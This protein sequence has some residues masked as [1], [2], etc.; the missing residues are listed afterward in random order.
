MT[1]GGLRQT[2]AQTEAS[3][4][5]CCISALNL[6]GER[7]VILASFEGK[8]WYSDS[9]G[10]PYNPGK[11]IVQPA[12]AE[13]AERA[14]SE[15]QYTLVGGEGIRYSKGWADTNV[16]SDVALHEG[17]AIT[18]ATS[19]LSDSRTRSNADW[20][21]VCSACGEHFATAAS[22]GQCGTCG[23][24]KCPECRGCDCLNSQAVVCPIC[25]QSLSM[26]EVSKG[27]TVHEDC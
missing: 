5:T 4:T 9:N 23:D 21:E 12:L 16:S 10:K 2:V 6:P 8:I 15:G 20:H 14:L 26:L 24:W 22:H 11:R 18:V 3:A 17:L 19:T 27:L 13:A 25:W 7:L 1:A